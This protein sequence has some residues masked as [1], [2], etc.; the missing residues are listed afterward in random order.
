MR[1][2]ELNA[3]IKKPTTSRNSFIFSGFKTLLSISLPLSWVW[4]RAELSAR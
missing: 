3:E 1:L 2:Q 4:W